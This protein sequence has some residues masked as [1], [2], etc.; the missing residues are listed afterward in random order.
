MLNLLHPENFIQKYDHMWP[1]Q[2]IQMKFRI[3]SLLFKLSFVIFA[4]VAGDHILDDFF[5]DAQDST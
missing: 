5:L 1:V 2:K 3:V 4:K